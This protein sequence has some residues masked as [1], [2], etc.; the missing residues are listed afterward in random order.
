MDQQPNN[1]LP[2]QVDTYWAG[3]SRGVYAAVLLMYS[4]G[5]KQGR[6]KLRDFL[7]YVDSHQD[8]STMFDQLKEHITIE[9]PVEFSPDEQ[10]SEEVKA[11]VAMHEIIKKMRTISNTKDEA[12]FFKK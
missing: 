9:V 11:E 6:G 2:S 12:K 4:L 8:V 3:Y 10:V 5:T 7:A 1:S